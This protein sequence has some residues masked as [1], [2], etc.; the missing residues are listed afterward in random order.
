MARDLG[1][2]KQYL[3]AGRKLTEKQLKWYETAS[4]IYDQQKYMYDNKVHSVPDRIVSFHQ[5]F[6]RPIVRGKVKTPVEFGV[7]LDIS[8]VNGL[9]RLEKQSFDT[10]NEGTIL[11]EEIESYRK[12]YGCYPEKVLADK[13]Y[14]TRENRRY[15]KENG[16]TMSGTALGR[17][18]KD[19]TADKKAEYRDECDRVEAERRFSLAKHK[20]CL[21]QLRTYLKETS[22]T[23]IALSILAMNLSRGYC[24]HFFHMLQKVLKLFENYPHYPQ[25]AG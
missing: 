13:I 11:I 14:R 7:K 12:R 1:Y 20:F 22:Q 23:V 25:V 18:K 17:A 8:V 19:A 4:A 21:S 5:P 15:C 10:Y 3:E 2:V 6:I 16:I 9:V 24:C